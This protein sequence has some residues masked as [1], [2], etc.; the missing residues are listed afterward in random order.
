MAVTVFI[1]RTGE[2]FRGKFAVIGDDKVTLFAEIR[3]DMAGAR[4][5]F[6]RKTTFR[7]EEVEVL[8]HQR[9]LEVYEATAT[10]AQKSR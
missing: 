4:R 10:E 3:A 6:G 8:A 5:G 7:A 9:D 1:K 2:R